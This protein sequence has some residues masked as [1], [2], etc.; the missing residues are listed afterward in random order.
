MRLRGF[1]SE[2][3]ARFERVVTELLMNT[4]HDLV[5]LAGLLLAGVLKQV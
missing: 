5:E 4:V 1:L 3:G 2:Q